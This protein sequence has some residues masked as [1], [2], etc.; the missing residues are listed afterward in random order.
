MG[1][2]RLK[3]TLLLA[4]LVIILIFLVNFINARKIP[5][6]ECR[7]PIITLYLHQEKRTV[8]LPFESYI[9]GVVAAEMPASFSI[10]AL[11][12]Q[13]LC[14]RTYACKKILDHK[15]YPLGANLSDD[16]TTCQAYVSWEEFQMLHPAQFQKLKEK[17][18][19]AVLLTRAEIITFEQRPIDALYHSTCGGFTES[20]SEVWKA[21]IP[22]LQSVKCNY[23]QESRY[24]ET[25]Q[26]ISYQ[27]IYNVTGIS[28][29]ND[30]DIFIK[31]K[32]QSGRSQL[33][34]IFNSEISAA[35]FRS[36]FNLP[37]TYWKFKTDN[38]NLIISSKGYGHGVGM[39]QYG[40]GGMAQSG[41]SYRDILSYY[42]K[43]TEIY[44]LDY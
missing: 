4:G 18:E 9:C 10:E 25:T 11:K 36:L 1:K 17:I 27:N 29:K 43:G 35:K 13:A 14:A 7:E 44:T 40:A 6:P 19:Q 15:E 21:D 39:C 42:Y 2:R 12:A 33:L 37:S 5:W 23:C 32:S 34:E 31:D 38:N 20:A 22:Y 26:V 41:K 30:R 24:Y 8:N 3:K 28:S 16:I